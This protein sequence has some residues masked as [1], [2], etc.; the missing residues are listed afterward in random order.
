MLSNKNNLVF[1]F[2]VCFFFS[3][4]TD[5]NFYLSVPAGFPKPEIPAENKLSRAK[6]DLGKKLFFDPLLSRDSSVSC[7]SCHKPDYAF[8]DGLQTAV[9]IKNRLVT[10][11]TPTLTNIVYNKNFLNTRK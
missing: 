6:I 5:K 11:N 3:F 1:L 8:T 9:G 2:L 10:R 4:D 7:A